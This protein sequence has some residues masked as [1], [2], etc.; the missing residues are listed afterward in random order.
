MLAVFNHITTLIT[1]ISGKSKIYWYDKDEKMIIC[2]VK[3][4]SI[5]SSCQN[6]RRLQLNLSNDLVNINRKK[7]NWIN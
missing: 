5:N 3:I 4:M 6:D 2:S 7:S 1:S